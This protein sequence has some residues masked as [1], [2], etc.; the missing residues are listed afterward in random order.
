MYRGRGD[1][2]R[3]ARTSIFG[4]RRSTPIS[5]RCC[6]RCRAS[7]MQPGER[8]TPI[9]E[10]QVEP[11]HHLIAAG[12]ARRPA[13]P[14]GPLLEV[15]DL[16]KTL[17]R[18]AAAAWL[19]G[20][21]RA[22]SSPSTTSSFDDRARRDASASSA[23]A[24]AARP[25]VS[26]MIMR[27]VRARR[28]PDRL[29]NDRRRRSTCWRSTA[30][31]LQRVP[32]PGPVHLPGPVRLAQPAHDGVRHPR[33]AAGHPRHRR[34]GRALRAGE[35]AARRWSG[36]TCATCAAIRTASRAASGSASASRARW[37]SSPSC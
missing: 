32:P 18:P 11:T 25:R 13:Q 34:R 30:T 1:G 17:R 37:R 26:K 24:A 23:R 2:A 33:R 15:A 3:H 22:A 8:L 19:G 20:E 12:R 16:R 6:A 7:H 14:D 28:G 4:A 31:T 35:G 5:R 29:Y 21:G 27:A 10:M 36:S 9:R